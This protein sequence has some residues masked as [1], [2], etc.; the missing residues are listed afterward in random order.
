MMLSKAEISQSINQSFNQSINQPTNQPTNQASKQAINQSISIY[1]YQ[2]YQLIWLIAVI[3]GD[4]A[5]TR[6][7][8]QRRLR[9][10]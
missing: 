2:Y 1:I 4:H 9:H 5:R 3:D 10:P 6:R 8:F 7:K